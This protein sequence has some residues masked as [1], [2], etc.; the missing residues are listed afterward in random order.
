MNETSSTASLH[1]VKGQPVEIPRTKIVEAY[2][3]RKCS[4]LVEQILSG[5]IINFIIA[6]E[7]LN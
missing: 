1:E 2:G 4:K 7:N 6:I 5:K 3:N